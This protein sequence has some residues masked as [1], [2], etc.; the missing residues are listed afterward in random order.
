MGQ[1]NNACDALCGR[2]GC[3]RREGRGGS[4][5]DRSVSF[6]TSAQ[7]ASFSSWS[8]YSMAVV[9]HRQ[10]YLRTVS[11]RW[12]MAAGRRVGGAGAAAAG[13]RGGLAELPRA[14]PSRAHTAA[15]PPHTPRRAPHRSGPPRGAPAREPRPAAPQLPVLLRRYHPA[16]SYTIL[17]SFSCS[18][19]TLTPLTT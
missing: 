17:S 13:S 4:P 18:Y 5:D 15:P 8:R 6:I 9:F 10:G 12:S 11:M 7:A 2:A 16:D 19:Y 14:G 3:A 1:H